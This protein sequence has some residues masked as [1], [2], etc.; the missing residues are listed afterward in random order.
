MGVVRVDDD[1]L[2]QLKKQLKEEENRYKY[3]SITSLLNS[4]IHESFKKK[5]GKK[6]GN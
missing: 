2:R 5:G 3:S 1:L 6:D 4:I